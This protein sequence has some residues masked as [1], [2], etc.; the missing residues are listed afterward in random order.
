MVSRSGAERAAACR[1]A[2][3]Q[4]FRACSSFSDFLSMLFRMN[5]R[6]PNGPEMANAMKMAMVG[7]C[8]K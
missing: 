3:P 7:M 5:S 1:D 2:V 6:R 8:A 4:P